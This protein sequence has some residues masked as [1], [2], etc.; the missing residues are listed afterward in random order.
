MIV[1]MKRMK[2]E[3]R[4]ALK[5]YKQRQNRTGKLEK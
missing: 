5:E 2:D 4:A 1:E 3:V